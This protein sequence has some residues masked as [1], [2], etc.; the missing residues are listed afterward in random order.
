MFLAV[1]LLGACAAGRSSPDAAGL[2]GGAPSFEDRDAVVELRGIVGGAPARCA[3]VLV[4]R[5]HVVSA[6]HC[7]RVLEADHAAIWIG[8][9]RHAARSMA[10][11]P[12][13]DVLVVT[14]AQA[15]AAEPI[16]IDERALGPADVGTGVIILGIE[17]ELAARGEPWLAV[18]P[19]VELE[20]TRATVDGSRTRPVC[21]GD[22][23][24]P[25]L[26][27]VGGELRVAGV[28]SSGALDC[29]G[30]GRYARLD[31]VRQWLSE[32]LR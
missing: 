28:L 29:S 8:D 6:A 17:G 4:D 22:S 27:E 5:T 18:Q 9:R 32:Q 7:Q 13:R 31:V 16:E 12:M 21:A 15:A 1:L 3:G 2:G 24:G 19:I 23:G 26:R 14:L 10:R 11:H 20:D 25:M 30:R